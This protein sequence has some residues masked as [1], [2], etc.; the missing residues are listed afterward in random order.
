MTVPL[1]ALNQIDSAQ[2]EW[3]VPGMLKEKVQ[4]L[5]KS[6]PQRL[7]RHLVPLP[8][9]AAEFAERAVDHADWRREP[10]IDALIADLRAERGLAVVAAD[11]RQLE[12]GRNLA[13]LKAELGA[14][15]QKS[16]QAV[17]AKGAKLDESL[18]GRITD[19][20]FGTL[21][22]LLEV[23]RD[24]KSMVGFPALVDRGDHC[25]IE[26]FDEP[27]VA[28]E[29]LRA[30]LRRLF[31]LQLREQ[32]R[33]LEKS[34]SSLQMA[35]MQAGAAGPLLAAGFPSFE[36][37]RDQVVTAAVDRT[38]LVDPWPTD[39]ESFMQRK[40]EGRAKLNLI[41]QELARLV[42]TIAQEAATLPRKLAAFKASPAIVSDVEVQLR[43]LFSSRF[44]VD[45]PA[46]ALA[47][48]PR[49]L[50]AIAARLEKCKENPARD[51]ARMAEIVALE[52]PY[53][54]EVAARKGVADVRLDE[55]RWLLEEL[56]VSLFAQELRTPMPVSSKRL[57]K[58]W[59]SARR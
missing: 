45:V 13:Q 29:R 49:Y 4:L 24:G 26:V 59:E 22:E 15:A 14:E 25:T 21:P 8:A 56:R 5:Y 11:M 52:T 44:V 17:A 18:Q 27:E 30:G 39:R 41:A 16:F 40:D 23:A 55:F 28:R 37:L 50:K 38:C 7:R 32:V 42:A 9:A 43:R 48:Y 51:A 54:R 36:E 33:F 46:G 3:L 53:W 19:W 31:R 57:Q 35:Q 12:L 58:V 6:L 47:H 2:C 10:L 20:D 34:L 1:A